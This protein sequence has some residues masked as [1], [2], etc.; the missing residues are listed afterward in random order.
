MGDDM[1]KKKSW[2]HNKF[3]IVTLII[4]SLI[5]S[6]VF[7]NKNF[8]LPNGIFKDG[9]LLVNNI[10]GKPIEFLNNNQEIIE[11]NKYLKK[12]IEE[13]SVYETKNIEL[14]E[15]INELKKVL[16]IN[17]LLSD[18]EYINASVINRNLDYWTESLIIDKGIKDGITSNMAVVSEGKM[19]GIT[20]NISSHNSNVLLFCNNKFPLNISVKIVFD[21][22]ELFGIL[23]NYKDGFYEIVGIVE[24]IDIPKDALV[25]T[26][27]LGNIFPSGIMIGKVD[28]VVTDNF[29]LSKIV[30]VNPDVDF[31]DISYVTV[32]KGEE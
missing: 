29:D 14:N 19:I 22:E 3:L 7:I 20:N 1:Y 28:D 26:A 8:N 18:G 24:N 4:L 9:V 25:M 27:G 17:K 32:I 12:R 5:L 15:E 6:S 2:Y 31:D 21:D 23:N 16:K 11:E 30:M 13:L 10:L